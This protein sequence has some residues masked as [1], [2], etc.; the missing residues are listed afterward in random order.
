MSQQQNIKT[1]IVT[2]AAGY[3]GGAICIELKKQGY[4]VVGIDRRVSPHLK[5]YYDEFIQ[6]DFID[7]KSLNCIADNIPNSIIHCA[8]TSLVGP[9]MTDPIEYYENNVAKTAKYLEY[10]TKYSPGTKF[11]F[12]SSASV[13][14]NPEKSHMLFEK[15]DTN[16]ISP[17]GES[18]LMTEM[19]LN[20]HNKA[21]GLQYV[22]FRYFN[23]CGAVEGGIHGQEPN[24]THI[25]AKIFEA[26]MSNEAFT[27][28]GIDYPTKDRTCVRDYIHVTDIAKAHIL[29]IENNLKGIYNIGS[30]KGHSNLEVFVKTENFLLDA[31]RIGDGIVFNVAPRRD[32]DPAILIANSEKLQSETSWKPEC[33]LDKI[34][35]DL[36]DWYDSRAFQEMAK[37]SP[38]F[39]P[40]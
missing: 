26:A 35:E 28:Y 6:C 13:Y 10:I 21:Y 14:G 36:F 3:I 25:F 1:V 27:M 38:A 4:R 18:K 23:A 32:G 33:D 20:W 5:S 12:S 39:T 15:S 17:Y 34:I 2:G 22:S 19:M 29:A 11:I 9:S 16:P 37:R 30:V 7:T 40:L 8:G 31:E 24:A